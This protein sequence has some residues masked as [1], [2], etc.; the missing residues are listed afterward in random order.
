MSI[1]ARGL[2]EDFPESP[3]LDGRRTQT[4]SDGLRA[5]RQNEIGDLGAVHELQAQAVDGDGPSSSPRD[6]ETPPAQTRDVERS[7]LFVEDDRRLFPPYLLFSF[8]F[9]PLP[10]LQEPVRDLAAGDGAG[11]PLPLKPHR[12]QLVERVACPARAVGQQHEPPLLVLGE[13]SRRL[14]GA[15]VGRDAVVEDPELVEEDR[16][17]ARER[18]ELGQGGDD[19]GRGRGRVCR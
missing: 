19:F 2:L 5:V 13:V 10:R 4:A 16:R 12:A 3:E 15:R 14:D 8:F 6:V 17:V 7:A 9:S 11:K 18:R 1:F